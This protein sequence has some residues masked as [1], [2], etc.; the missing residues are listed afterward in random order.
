MCKNTSVW[1]SFFMFYTGKGDTGSTKIFGCDKQ[2]S[3]SSIIIEALGSIDELNSFIGVCKTQKIA[4]LY[5]TQ[6]QS[7]LSILE[8]IQQKLFIIQAELAGAEK[9]IRKS[10][11]RNLENIIN[12]IGKQL[13]PINS[14][15]VSGGIEFA[16]LIDYTRTLSRRTERR[17]IEVK[18]EG[19]VCVGDQ[20]LVFLNRLS[21]VFFIMTRL[22]N[23]KLDIKEESPLY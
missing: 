1:Y 23:H 21:S 17:V 18:E 20:T 14:F 10:D 3:K 5:A 4:T 13:P 8:Q 12:E 6:R 11:V 16:A 22:V 7:F 9:T 15:L 2:I 19:S